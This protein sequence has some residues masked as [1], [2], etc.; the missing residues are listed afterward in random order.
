M[1]TA[2]IAKRKTQSI[3]LAMIGF[4]AVVLFSA[5]FIYPKVQQLKTQRSQIAALEMAFK[6][7]QILQPIFDSLVQGMNRKAPDALPC[8]PLEK[9]NRQ[10]TRDILA[11][12]EKIA[13]QSDLRLVHITPHAGDS[14]T[15]QINVGFRGG[16]FQLRALLLALGRLPY[17]K[18]V[19]HFAVQSVENGRE[20]QLNLS[21]AQYQS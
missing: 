21:I 1:T 2:T 16:F 18:R 17:V 6:E 7:R 20:I 19:D 11:V 3:L 10:A 5:V 13:E 12:C 15:L 8:P 4:G 9:L 14:D